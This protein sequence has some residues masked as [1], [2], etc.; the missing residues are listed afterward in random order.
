MTA[1]GGEL[2]KSLRMK[3][4]S[5]DFFADEYVGKQWHILKRGGME[6]NLNADPKGC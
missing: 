5:K 1:E 6:A 4:P 3:A 2:R